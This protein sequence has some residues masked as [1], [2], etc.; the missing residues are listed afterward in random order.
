MRAKMLAH[1][2]QQQQHDKGNNTS[3]TAQTRQL[4][5]GNNAGAT[6]VT[7][8]MWREGKEVI[9]IRTTMLVQQGQ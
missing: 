2:G 8:P 3:A 4:N 6:T 9:V 5:G 1:W 7:T